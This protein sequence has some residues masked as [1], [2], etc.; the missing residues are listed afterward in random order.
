MATGEDHVMLSLEL[1][2]LVITERV[3]WVTR[4]MIQLTRKK[5]GQTIPQCYNRDIERSKPR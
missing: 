5:S 3:N 2:V 1:E 4:E